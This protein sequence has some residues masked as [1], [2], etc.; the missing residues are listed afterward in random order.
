MSAEDVVEINQFLSVPRLGTYIDLVK[1]QSPEDA[2]ELHQVTMSLGIAIMAVTGLIEVSLRNTACKELDISFGGAGWLRSPPASLKWSGF[3]INAINTAEKHARRAVY[4]KMDGVSKSALDTLAFPNGTPQ[5]IKH[6]KLAEKRQATIQV[7]DSQV[8]AQLTMNFWKRLYSINYDK[9]LWKRGLKR[10]F[11]NKRLSRA[12]IA[13]HLEVIY[14]TR[15]RLAHHEPVYG[16][17]LESILNAIEFV[18]T[19][20]GSVYSSED[21]SFSKLIRPQLDILAGQVAVFKTTFNRLC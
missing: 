13:S 18:S 21:N 6:R 16:S 15:N 10:T 20:L 5:G 7:A 1:S 3:E 4:S 11:P 19:N 2:I 8:I 9:T 17:R 14:E 12:D